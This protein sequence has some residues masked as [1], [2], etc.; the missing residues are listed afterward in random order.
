[1]NLKKGQSNFILQELINGRSRLLRREQY[2]LVVQFHIELLS[3]LQEESG[4]RYKYFAWYISL[5][6][7]I[8]FCLFGY[9][10]LLIVFLYSPQTFSPTQGK[11]YWLRALKNYIS[12]SQ[13]ALKSLP[14]DSLD[15]ESGGY[16][17]LDSSTKLRLL[18]YLCDEV[19][20]TA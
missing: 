13:N 10:T 11:N 3:L 20:E 5:H 16:D 18:N 1:M 17:T 9:I 2:S 6:A 19:L 4:S 14:F 15:G 7:L 12:G 8:S